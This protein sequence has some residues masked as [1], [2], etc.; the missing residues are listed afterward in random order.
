MAQHVKKEEDKARKKK[1]EELMAAVSRGDMN[2]IVPVGEADALNTD[3]ML[4]GGNSDS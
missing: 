2:S 1:H 3:S 4:L